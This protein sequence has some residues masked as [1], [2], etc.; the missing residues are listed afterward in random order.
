ME[1]SIALYVF[2]STRRRSHFWDGKVDRSFWHR[3]VDRRGQQ[4]AS[5]LERKLPEFTQ[6][7]AE[8]NWEIKLAKLK[9]LLAEI[10][11]QVFD[12]AKELRALREYSNTVDINAENYM[13][14]YAKI[15]CCPLLKATIWCFFPSSGVCAIANIK[16][17]L[18]NT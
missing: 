1:R 12:Y 18:K 3:N 4:I 5:E 2:F 11:S 15:K 16:V 7:E 6:I 10:R 14:S 13:E 17:K 9:K 8:P